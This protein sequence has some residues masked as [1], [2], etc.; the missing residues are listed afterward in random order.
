MRALRTLLL[1]K[2]LWSKEEQGTPQPF[3][4]PA[5]RF[6]G[7]ALGERKAGAMPWLQQTNLQ[8][9]NP[10]RREGGNYHA[11]AGVASFDSHN[12][13]GGGGKGHGVCEFCQVATT[14]SC[15]VEGLRKHALA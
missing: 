2:D 8:Q 9:T 6:R 5:L 3:A 4:W 15:K 1:K 10:L 12:V 7:P 14:R 13:H 11:D